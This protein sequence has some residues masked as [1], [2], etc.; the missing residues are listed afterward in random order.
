MRKVYFTE[1]NIGYGQDFAWHRG[2]P[3]HLIFEEV[4]KGVFHREGD[5]WLKAPGYGKEPYGNG[6]IVVKESELE[7]NKSVHWIE[8]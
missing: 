8:E 7:N 5:L 4:D 2:L 6:Q 1:N 3:A